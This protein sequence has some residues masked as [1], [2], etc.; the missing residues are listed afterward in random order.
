MKTRIAVLF[1]GK[2]V[3]HEVSVIS[4]IQAMMS[5]DKEKYDLIPVYIT[6]A[7][8][9]YIGE[10]I[11]NIEAYKDINALLKKSQRVIWVN[12]GNE[13]S[14]MPYPKKLFK[15]EKNISV[16]IAFPIVHGTN[17]EDGTLQGYLKTLGIPFVGCD[18]TASAVGMDKYIQKA[19]LKDNGI[20]VLDCLHFTLSDYTEVDTMV[21]KIEEKIGYPV[22][23][24]PVNTGS[25]VG[26]SVAKDKTELVK[27]IDDA[28]LYAKKILVEHAILNLREI[29]CAVLG[30]E[31]EA[32][33]SECE[34]PLHTKDI[35]SYEDKYMGSNAKKGGSKGMASVSRKIPAELTPEK[36]KEVQD[37]AV[38]AF[39]CLGCNG[40]S[41]M[42]F[43]IDADNDQLYFNE[44]NTIPGSL[45][46]YL[47]E[48]IGIQYSEL[49][50]RMIQLALKR[51]R[52]D[53]SL[54]F[55]FDT[56]ILSTQSLSGAKGTKGAKC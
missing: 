45:A 53:K 54:T 49:L 42:D 7:N 24:K 12:E 27:S 22:I 17:E 6:K 29:N 3:E 13:V 50:D 31:N 21:Q 39:Q 43:M 16:D 32:I 20:P 2:S 8:E 23:V 40:V 15:N 14:L 4:G 5:M 44:I 33:P 46:F 35:L 26:I 1:G 10:E 51:D 56:N 37:Y 9:M 55:T 41:R 34:E 36:R 47:W 25:S 38:K 30:D 18:V 11:G 52:E 48:P 28:Y 19:V